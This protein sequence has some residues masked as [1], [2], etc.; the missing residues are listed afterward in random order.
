MIKSPKQRHQGASTFTAVILLIVRPKK[1]EESLPQAKQ[2]FL[3][4]KQYFPRAKQRLVTAGECILKQQ[5]TAS[6]I[7]SASMLALHNRMVL[8]AILNHQTL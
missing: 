6:F 8:F 7:E 4:K 5:G 3:L 1:A 2:I